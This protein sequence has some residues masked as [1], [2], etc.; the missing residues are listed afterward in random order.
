VRVILL[1]FALINTEVV[2]KNLLFLKVVLKFVAD[3]ES[4]LN[5][6]VNSS[7]TSVEFL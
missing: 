7:M 5:S 6:L 1:K 2:V 4:F 3:F